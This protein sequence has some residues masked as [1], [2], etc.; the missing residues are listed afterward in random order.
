MAIPTKMKLVKGTFRKDRANPDEP[1]Y[2][3]ELP[4]PPVFLNALGRVEWDRM[5]EFF[6]SQGLLTKV[7]MAA[8]ASYCHLYG[9]WAEAETRLNVEKLLIETKSGNIIQNPLLGVA[10]T[11]LREMNKCLKEFGMTPASRSKV[12]TKKSKRKADPWS[13]F[14]MKKKPKKKPK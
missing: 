7:D 1:D 3:I 13:G 14:G 6:F 5:A 9:R 12:S 8:L 10:N 2:E 11:A 4:E